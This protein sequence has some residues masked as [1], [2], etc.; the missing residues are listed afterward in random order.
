MVL[1]P[2][3][4]Q[5][6]AEQM[7]ERESAQHDAFLR[8]V[9][10]AVREDQFM[11][12]VRRYARPVGA[13]IAAGLAVLAGTLAWNSHR[14]SQT[15]QR[16][17]RLTVALDQIEAGRPADA[18]G[19]LTALAGEGGGTAAVA[20]L[21]AAGVALKD[22]KRAEALAAYEA[23]AADSS[24]PQPYRDLATVRAVATGF[25]TM[26][27][28][29][30]ISRLKLLAVPGNP[31]FASAGELTALAQIKAGHKE[32]A[33]PLLGA[34]AKDKDAPESARARAR[35]LA[36]AFGFDAVDDIATSP[37]GAPAATR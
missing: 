23:V 20:R 12:A 10:D 28:D 1:R 11:G 16:S 2:T 15:E 31:W 5:S 30:V 17:E 21:L 25:D 29:Q 27:P 8:E 37:A 14:T 7:A 18:K 6:R 13:G 22:G 19:T 4:P 33:G 9:D 24:A 35:Q 3:R 26:K 36:G 34:I 32:L